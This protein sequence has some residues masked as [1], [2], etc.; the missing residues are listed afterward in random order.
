MRKL[1]SM[2]ISNIRRF[3]ENVDIEISEGVTII[4]APNGTGKSTIFQAI[5]F[6]LTGKVRGL[7]GDLRFLFND[8]KANARGEVCL[9]FGLEGICKA[10]WKD[11]QLETHQVPVDFFGRVEKADVPYALGL[12]HFLDQRG[13]D[14]IVQAAAGEAGD[15]FS[16]LSVTREVI[17]ARSRIQ[18][19]K[20]QGT[21]SIG[22]ADANLSRSLLPL[23]EWN[24]A[25]EKLK[26]SQPQ[27]DRPLIP[28][29][30]ILNSLNLLRERIK[31]DAVHGD[32]SISSVRINWGEFNKIV[33]QRKLVIDRQ[34]VS[35]EAL[36][37]DVTGYGEILKKISE[38]TV[39]LS[40]IESQH[41]SLVESLDLPKGQK[42][43]LL[44]TRDIN[45]SNARSF[46]LI[47]VQF[48]Q[49]KSMETQSLDLNLEI[50]KLRIDLLRLAEKEQ[51]AQGK[52]DELQKASESQKVLQARE[53]VI[54]QQRLKSDEQEKWIS[55]CEQKL[56]EI[57]NLE[58]VDLARIDLKISQSSEA[59]QSKHK[60]LD[61]SK[62]L[63]SVAQ[64]NYDELIAISGDI[65]DAVGKIA[66]RL[67]KD[68][69]VCPVCL[70]EYDLGKLQLQ[71]IEA[72]NASNPEIGRAKLILEEQM[73]R[74]GV[75]TKERD[76]VQAILL[77]HLEEKVQITSRITKLNSEVSS[78]LVSELKST[79]IEQSKEY[80]FALN[81]EILTAQGKLDTDKANSIINPTEDEIATFREELLNLQ[82]EVSDLRNLAK[83]REST[84]EGIVAKIGEE[85][86]FLKEF[87]SI[88]S[89]RAKITS[90]D[91]M[92]KGLDEQIIQLQMTISRIQDSIQD[93]S[94]EIADCEASLSSL[95]GQLAAMKSRWTLSNLTGDPKADLLNDAIEGNRVKAEELAKLQLELNILDG[96]IARIEASKD[97]L[98]ALDKL[99]ELRKDSTN[100]IYEERLLFDIQTARDAHAFLVMKKAVLDTFSERLTEQINA[101]NATI[102]KMNRPFQKILSR[103]VMDARFQ[104]TEIASTLPSGKP[105]LTTSVEFANKTELAP[106][107]R[108][109]SEAQ[110]AEVQ[111]AFLLAKAQ[112]TP[113]CSWRALLLDDPTQ[114]HDLVHA[115]GVFDVLRD[116]SSKG[117]D[118]QML[119]ATHDSVQARFFMRKLENDGIPVKLL[120]LM[121][122]DDGVRVRQID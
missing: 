76:R 48:E 6:A 121:A 5:E 80:L 94:K 16:R 66:I 62:E 33:E 101:A 93:V 120:S 7:G 64:K 79:T 4:L 8:K 99:A 104:S 98:E 50:E 92:I 10:V 39:E 43:T 28:I 38:A 53:L 102:S 77:E 29:L 23:D 17:V 103:I 35:F 59:L 86:A 91:L 119:V 18:A 32:G 45:V 63:L 14:W 27:L 34:L 65:A 117:F 122:G 118:F 67:P 41:L 106:V 70:K 83:L 26:S 24:E 40:K 112:I 72:V 68:T 75:S 9:D 30:E 88:E 22:E 87:V 73:N 116:Y 60:E 55:L 114:H 85:A 115:S 51:D 84:L 21:K 107:H 1:K 25:K 56:N 89:I 19:L 105:H 13:G 44:T 11:G 3:G 12:T 95:R 15:Q 74:L 81:L 109:A 58:L 97:F 108:I 42:D 61:A 111:L 49:M 37:P 47:E 96:E 54:K 110:L 69:N 78:I 46:R 71:I 90:E 52:Y 31:V 36:K 113:W 2:L 57:S 82:K 20:I 100:E